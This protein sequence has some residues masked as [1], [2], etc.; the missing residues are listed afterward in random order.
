MAARV[1]TSCPP[2]RRVRGRRA[3]FRFD[4]H[5]KLMTT[6]DKRDGTVVL[7]SK[8]APE[9]VLTHAVDLLDHGT[10]RAHPRRPHRGRARRRPTGR[11]RA[12]GPRRG[13][14]AAR[15]WAAAPC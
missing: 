1:G 6:A 14:A 3:L 10:E 15:S 11:A 13:A 5:V 2:E 12:A 7:H 9:E 8:G 4:P